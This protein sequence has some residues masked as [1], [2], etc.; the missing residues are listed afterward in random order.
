[1]TSTSRVTQQKYYYA[2]EAGR[3]YRFAWPSD[4]DLFVAQDAGR[5]A[6][7]RASDLRVVDAKDAAELGAYQW[8]AP[9]WGKE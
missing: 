3:V 2:V 9:E 6:I 8:P 5:R 1:M 7:V 4:R